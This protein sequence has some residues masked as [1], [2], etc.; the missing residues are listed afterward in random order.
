MKYKFLPDE[1]KVLL[2]FNGMDTILDSIEN[3]NIEDLEKL[4]PKNDKIIQNILK[5]I[6]IQN[7]QERLCFFYNMVLYMYEDLKKKN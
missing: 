1:R 3:I 2:T 4:I 5:G 6:H 7:N